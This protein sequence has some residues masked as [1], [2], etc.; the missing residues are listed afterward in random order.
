MTQPTQQFTIESNAFQGLNTEM[1]P[2]GSDP[3]YALTADNCVIDRVIG[4]I[5]ARE[6][7]APETLIEISSIYSDIDI[8]AISANYDV[9]GIE[10][11]PKPCTHC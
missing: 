3:S 6:A 8:T 11:H 1:N 9:D 2:I 5:S 7:F 10:Y 4:R